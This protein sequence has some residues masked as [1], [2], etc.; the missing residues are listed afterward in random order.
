ME[1][2]RNFFNNN[3]EKKGFTLL[4]L[5]IVIA[6]LA[7]L[8][9]IVV[10]TLNPAELLS[11][12]RDTK[13][14]SDLSSIR[15]AINLYITDL[16]SPDLDGSGSY[17]CTNNRFYSLPSSRASTSLNAGD[18]KDV[19]FSSSSNFRKVDGDGW[20]PIVFSGISSGSPLASLPVDPTNATSSVAA[21][22]LYY[23]YDCNSTNTTFELNTQM[24][25][26]YFSNGGSGD[27]E[28]TDGGDNDNLFEV[29]S[30]PSLDL[31]STTTTYFF[32]W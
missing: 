9:S 25:S 22:N 31:A 20:M 13:R 4:E 27:V 11:K 32:Q 21:D 7:I 19:T 10:V 30:D 17:S 6:I 15:T 18:G 8:M 2:K 14:I 3:Q 5:L 24:E 29:G 28:T 23:T 1:Q 12:S 16:A 26:V